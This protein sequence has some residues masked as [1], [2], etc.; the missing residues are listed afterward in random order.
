MQISGILEFAC[1]VDNGKVDDEVPVWLLSFFDHVDQL[2]DTALELFGVHRLC[3]IWRGKEITSGLDPGTSA[4][5]P[6]QTW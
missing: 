4:L 6:I 3:S 2:L 5:N 1:L